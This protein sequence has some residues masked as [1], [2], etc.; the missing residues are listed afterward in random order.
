[1]RLAAWLQY[2]SAVTDLSPLCTVFAAHAPS[3]IVSQLGESQ[4]AELDALLQR[5]LDAG[6]ACWPGMRVTAPLFVLHIAER[7]GNVATL[8]EA[9]QSIRALH[10]ADLYLACGCM[11][12]IGDALQLF[13]RSV[14][15]RVPSFLSQL[16]L[17]AALIDDVQQD[18][19]KKLLVWEDEQPPGL[20]SYS[21]RGELANFVRVAAIRNAHN[22]RRTQDEK[23]ERD[24]GSLAERLAVGT[25]DPAIESLKRRYRTEFKE[26]I[27]AA[28]AELASEHRNLLRLYYVEG[29]PT[30][31]LAAVFG[32]N[33]SN[34]SRRLIAVRSAIFDETQRQLR[35]RLRLTETAF[36]E[37]SKLVL[38]QLDVSL[39]RLLR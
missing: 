37:L 26:G 34:I 33:Q 3:Q 19:R 23:A 27:S 38:S 2:H 13:D 39:S 14:I 31:Q 29:L 11:Y 17:P 18:L 21:G 35:K 10:A 12:G 16:R 24:D 9:M 25:S 1:M 28:I 22:K 8:D 36:E 6:S 30:T 7:L 4:A 20:A 15:A 5:Q 32:V